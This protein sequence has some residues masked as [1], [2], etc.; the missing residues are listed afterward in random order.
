MD[1]ASN[2]KISVKTGFLNE[3]IRTTVVVGFN[4][5]QLQLWL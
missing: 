4:L 2:Y 3:S 5:A 1:A